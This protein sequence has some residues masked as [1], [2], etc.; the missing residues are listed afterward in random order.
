[1]GS[2]SLGLTFDIPVHIIFLFSTLAAPPTP[3]E[4]EMVEGGALYLEK[5]FL[6]EP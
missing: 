5:V 1:M 6:D 4:K 2:Q 3:A